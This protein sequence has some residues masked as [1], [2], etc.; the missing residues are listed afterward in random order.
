MPCWLLASF[1]TQDNKY[2][3]D[4]QEDALI[5]CHPLSQGLAFI[6]HQLFHIL[7]RECPAPDHFINLSCSQQSFALLAQMEK[8]ISTMT[9]DTILQKHGP[10]GLIGEFMWNKKEKQVFHGP[11]QMQI[12]LKLNQLLACT[13]SMQNDFKKG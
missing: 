2:Y 10:M 8:N 3:W 9:R 7:V 6:R 11:H 13:T 12:L 1:D 5:R 4:T